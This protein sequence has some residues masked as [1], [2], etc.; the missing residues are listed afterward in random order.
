MTSTLER[1]RLA[2]ATRPA[3]TPD[4]ALALSLVGAVAVAAHGASPPVAVA[5]VLVV[6]LLG[7]V[8]AGRRGPLTALNAGTVTLLLGLGIGVRWTDKSP[9]T[10]MA[11]GGVACL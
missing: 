9:L 2:A 4:V 11:I 10:V 5:R 1:P 6:L 7:Y 3:R 8:A